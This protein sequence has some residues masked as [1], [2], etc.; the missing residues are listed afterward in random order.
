MGVL[1]VQ[2]DVGEHLAALARSGARAAA[3][4]TAAD[5][6]TVGALVVPGGESTTVI[7]LLDRFGLAGPIVDRVRA[8]MPFWGTCMGMIVAAHG[9]AGL[10]QPTLDLID[11]TVRRN[12]FGRQVDSA[13]VPLE[14]P[15]LG[16]PAFPAIF[17][18]APWVERV[19]AGVTVLARRDGH[20]VFVRAGHVMAT[21]FHPELTA[22]DRVHAYFLSLVEES[23]ARTAA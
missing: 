3:V 10:A 19:G 8:G 2:G 14:I 4:K 17:I 15:A 20:P 16:D 13:E 7:R 22:D 18:R 11:I 5:L 6:Q 12:A 21:S 9:V 1:A 23:R